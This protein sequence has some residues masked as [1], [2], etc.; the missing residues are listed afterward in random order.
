MPAQVHGH[1]SS[2]VSKGVLP[3]MHILY[4][5]LTMLSGNAGH[6]CMYE[7]EP[8]SIYSHAFFPLLTLS[9]HGLLIAKHSQINYPIQCNRSRHH[10]GFT[11]RPWEDKN[12][13]ENM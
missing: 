8:T 3:Y 10:Q 11:K 12:W 13:E 6:H 9:S 4:D 7:L 5:S 2:G 1:C